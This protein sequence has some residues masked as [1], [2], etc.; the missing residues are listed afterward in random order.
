MQNKQMSNVWGVA[1]YEPLLVICV[2]LHIVFIILLL[3]LLVL[4][5]SLWVT[6]K[7]IALNT[8]FQDVT[9]RSK[10]II[11]NLIDKSILLDFTR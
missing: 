4:L 6:L 9:H 8:C 5:L 11:R 1:N 10:S 2:S 3:L 7:G